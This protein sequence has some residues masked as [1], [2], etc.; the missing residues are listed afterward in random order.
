MDPRKRMADIVVPEGHQLIDSIDPHQR[1]YQQSQ[2]LQV[3]GADDFIHNCFLKKRR[4]QF[5]PRA[6]NQQKGADNQGLPI[7]R[8]QKKESF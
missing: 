5:H 4:Y 6:S 3:T 1:H 2:S 8:Q 7:R